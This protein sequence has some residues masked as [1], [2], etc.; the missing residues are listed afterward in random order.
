[1]GNR[2][3]NIGEAAVR[4][5]RDVLVEDVVGT[6]Q[7]RRSKLGY[8]T[9]FGTFMDGARKVGS[10][11]GESK[12]R[13][14]EM[15]GA[16]FPKENQEPLPTDSDDPKERFMVA[17][18]FH[19]HQD[20]GLLK[21]QEN[22]WRSFMLYFVLMVASLAI[23]IA[24]LPH[25]IGGD[26][27][28]KFMD[29]GLRFAILMP[30]AA[31]TFRSGYTNWIVRRRSL[32]GP[33]S[34]LASFDWFPE[35][36][37][38]GKNSSDGGARAG[39]SAACA[40]IAAVALG[41]VMLSTPAMSQTPPIAPVAPTADAGVVGMQNP[42]EAFEVPETDDMFLR[43]LSY[44]VPNVGP[45]PGLGGEDGATT[46]GHTAIA[47][48]FAMF[49]SLLLFIASA[50]LSW[51]VVAGIVASASEG[52]VLGQ[53]WHQVWAPVRVTMG[54]GMLA[55]V[56]GGYCAAQILVL[57]LMVWGG[58]I[59]NIVWNPYI[60]AIV[61]S[62][63]QSSSP[64]D[65]EKKAQNFA[66]LPNTNALVRDVLTREL[67]Y[68]GITVYARDANQPLSTSILPEE[69]IGP[70]EATWNVV[71]RLY[72]SLSGAFSGK[73]EAFVSSVQPVYW[74][75]GSVCGEMSTDTIR[76]ADHRS[77]NVGPETR[78]A[79]LFDQ[80]RLTAVDNIRKKLRPLA[81]RTAETYS[82]QSASVSP[83]NLADVDS[84]APGA[85]DARALNDELIK[86]IQEAKQE[87]NDTMAEAALTFITEL[88]D[89]ED[90][91]KSFSVEAKRAGWAT[92]GVYYLTLSKLQGA[93]YAKAAEVPS[94][95]DINLDAFGSSNTGAAKYLANPEQPRGILV[96]YEIWWDKNLP[97][98]V[99]DLDPNSAK[100]GRINPQNEGKI[101]EFLSS[102]FS[103]DALSSALTH[104]TVDPLN[105]LSGMI[106]FG[107]KILNIFMTVMA[108]IALGSM[109]GGLSPIGIIT[110]IGA[111]IAAGGPLFQ[112]LMG[113]ATTMVALL[114]FALLAV[115]VVHAYVLP[116][117][118][119]IMVL[120]FV[121]GMLILVVE[122]MI[123]APLWAFFH[124]RMD[125]QEFVDNVQR[126]GYMIAF[127]LLLRPVLMVLGL[128][129]SLAVFGAMMWFLA[130]TFHVAAAAATADHSIGPIGIIVMLVILTYLHYQI[131]LRSFNLILQVPDRVM[132][133]FGQGGENLGEENESQRITGFVVS[134]VSNR[135]EGMTRAGGMGAA[136]K[137]NARNP[138]GNDKSGLEGGDAGAGGGGK[139]G[140]AAP[141]KPVS[142]TPE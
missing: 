132:R 81:Q 118:P 127:N 138:V 65:P 77:G 128:M 96:D 58:N 93:L 37:S 129:M 86:A 35:R 46:P 85:E 101:A 102:I 105:P 10:I 82:R 103:F 8:L 26:I 72:K 59:A 99:P 36:P 91:M 66:A 104:W 34:Y 76:E 126:P 53:R 11:A 22:T 55:P 42:I 12:S 68:A 100:A 56:A 54:V 25:S 110:K 9:G 69:P 32:E 23:G 116:L 87:Y 113:A 2:S 79:I 16:A 18:E 14:S 45:I 64:E 1:M 139:G 49:S 31:L 21:I 114:L 40:F 108:A 80:A 98:I 43:L 89:G 125:G 84:N 73:T 6:R 142:S 41:A 130:Q 107:H 60:D 67:C 131:A 3:K 33:G 140:G 19:G 7:W 120:F 141:T 94:F 137:Q 39:T 15:Y 44:V 124:V 106:D 17:S 47:A 71:E 51:H 24:S 134:N 123:A 29:Y 122:A 62:P 75:Y 20:E 63:I 57:Y 28:P 74:D 4:E 97:K 52:R 133:W 92:A 70:H 5:A 48:G 88:D 90:Y 109:V 135:V 95:E 13:I 38:A 83:F 117:I 111:K 115:G 112:H 78:A 27:L 136:V 119:Y 50:M 30:L 121:M 61:A